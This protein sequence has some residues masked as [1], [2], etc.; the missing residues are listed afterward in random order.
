M[1]NTKSAEKRV[2]QT[3]ARTSTNKATKSRVKSH[4]KALAAALESGDKAAAEASL[5]KLASAADRAAKSGVIHSNA[6]AR[7]KRIATSRVSALS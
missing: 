5:K 3:L 4:R 2:R 7:L 6:A 1:A